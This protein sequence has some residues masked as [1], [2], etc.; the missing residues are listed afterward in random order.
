[1]HA[2]INSAITKG[3]KVGSQNN[4][5]K[6]KQCETVFWWYTDGCIFRAFL[7]VTCNL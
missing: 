3:L 5:T 4:I 6:S 2:T 7:I 1:M